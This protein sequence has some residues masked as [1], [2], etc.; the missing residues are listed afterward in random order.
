MK[1]L[2]VLLP[3][4]FSQRA[5]NALEEAIYFCRKTESKLLIYHVFHRPYSEGAY[6]L[7][8]KAKTDKLEQQIE[9]QFR[10]LQRNHPKLGLIDH[11]FKKELGISTEKI[12]ETT[13]NQQIDL[14]ITATKGAIG[15]GELWGTKTAKIISEVKVPVLIIPDGA[16]L[17][18][19]KKIGLACDL[20]GKTNFDSLQLIVDLADHLKSNVDVISI[21]KDDT[22]QSEKEV[23]HSTAS[24]NREYVENQLEGIDTSF[25]FFYKNDIEHGLLEYSKENEISLLAILPKNY[26]FL[27][28][29][30]HDSVTKR[31]ILHSPIPLIVLK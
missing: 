18:S 2:K 3:F 20:S 26:S 30:F 8:L 1:P 5:N 15:I 23:M 13:Q 27:D 4:D 14:I 7:D 19:V 29:M 16:R 6:N 31:I 28:K 22:T 24:K 25:N 9:N 17:D 21:N 10:N 11:E 12:I